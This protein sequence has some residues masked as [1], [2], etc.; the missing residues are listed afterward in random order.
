MTC[1]TGEY[2]NFHRA[3]AMCSLSKIKEKGHFSMAVLLV[4]LR[5]RRAGINP[6]LS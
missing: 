6:T 3:Y 4:I 1:L 5:S 2:L